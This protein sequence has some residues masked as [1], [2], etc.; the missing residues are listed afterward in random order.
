MNRMSQEKKREEDSPPLRFALIHQH[1][2]SR[3]I[4]KNVK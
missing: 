2:K 4:F 3:N 1:K